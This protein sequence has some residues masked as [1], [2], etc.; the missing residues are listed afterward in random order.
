MDLVSLMSWGL[1]VNFSFTASC[2]RV[3]DPHMMF[4]AYPKGLG[5]GIVVVHAFNPRTQEG[6]AYL[7][8]GQYTEQVPEQPSIFK[9]PQLS[10]NL[11]CFI[12][13]NG[14]HMLCIL[15]LCILFHL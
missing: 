9:P 10:L 4:W 14:G 13:L 15:K 2:Y 5:S 12:L 3:W 7:S 11:I 8:Q 6:E 1:H